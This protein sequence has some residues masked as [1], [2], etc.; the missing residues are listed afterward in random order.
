[1]G[2]KVIE[3]GARRGVS[4]NPFI[5]S[6]M[7]ETSRKADGSGQKEGQ[8]TAYYTTDLWQRRGGQLQESWPLGHTV[9]RRRLLATGRGMP[10]STGIVHL[11]R[12]GKS[13]C[14]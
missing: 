2:R 6:I 3:M 4:I 5:A 7:R 13:H 12:G 14:S 9:A 10:R 11:Q 8:A 1:M